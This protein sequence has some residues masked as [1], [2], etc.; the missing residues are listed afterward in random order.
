VVVEGVEVVAVAEE[1]EDVAIKMGTRA[2]C[3]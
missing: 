3:Q 2:G 1:A